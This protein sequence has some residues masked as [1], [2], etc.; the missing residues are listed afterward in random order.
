MLLWTMLFVSLL[1][2][3]TAAALV[4]WRVENNKRRQKLVKGIL[5]GVNPDA[6]VVTT[7]STLLPVP[8]RGLKG[9]FKRG[10]P[11]DPGTGSPEWLLPVCW[12][13]RKWRAS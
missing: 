12:W 11:A 10:T 6:P 3:F 7:T 9:A 4:W 1:T 2:I 8:E 13:A 5:A